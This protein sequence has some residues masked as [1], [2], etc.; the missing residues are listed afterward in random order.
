MTVRDLEKH[1]PLTE[2]ILKR[3]VGS[4]RAVDGV[5]F[6]LRAGETLGLVGESGCGKSTTATTLLR[7][8][9]PTGGQV[10]FDGEEVTAFDDDELKRFR[11]EAQMIFQDPTSSFD[12]RMSVGESVTEALRIHGL[13]DRARRRA[14]GED[15]L[16]RVGLDAADYDRYP[17]EFSGGQ[18][19]RI[20]I[21]RA[22]VVNPQLIVA[23]EP[24]SALDVSVKSA[25]LDLLTDLQAEFGIA[26][27]FI[28]HD[29]SV[30]R[31]VADRVAVMYLGEIVEVAPTE[32]LF[33]SPEH[34]YTE[35]L[36]SAIP[37]PDPD[38]SGSTIQ[39]SG[40]VPSA[41][42]PPAGC[43]FHTRCPKVVQPEGVDLPQAVWRDVLDAR[44]RVRDDDVDVA[45]VK[46]LRAPA[47][48]DGTELGEDE[49]VAALR[50]EFDL[51]DELSDPAAERAVADALSALAAGDRE[52]A[53][54]AFDE[55]FT[56]P[57]ETHEPSRQPVAGSPDHEVACLLRH[58]PAD[59]DVRV[60]DEPREGRGA[61]AD[62]PSAPDDD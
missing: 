39:L 38:A 16:E 40:T 28:S 2:G 60:P 47:G 34:P 9:E 58:P 52:A 8:E 17:H 32:R 21:A 54:A 53:V 45:A 1:Y 24:V 49:T 10:R 29:L 25:V 27:L 41:S 18:K 23:D 51:P 36:L 4:V 12:P 37:D 31:E 30:V 14:V 57:C 3:Q 7:L 61:P 62:G 59:V 55:T 22:L 11:R 56:T 19:Q 33:E 26:M 44:L 42:D 48:A 35:S 15:L 50:A 13:S 5:S 6:D 20:A 43:R 46:E